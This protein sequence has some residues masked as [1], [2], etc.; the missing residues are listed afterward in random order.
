ML[1]IF[2]PN[3][4]VERLDL[5]QIMVDVVFIFSLFDSGFYI[6]TYPELSIYI[7]AYPELSIYIWAYPELS[8]LEVDGQIRDLCDFPLTIFILAVE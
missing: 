6:W 2:F 7:W 5:V 3:F 8:I 4:D 1:K